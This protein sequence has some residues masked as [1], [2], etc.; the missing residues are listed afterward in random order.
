VN[1]EKLNLFY[2]WME[3]AGYTGSI[4][5]KNKGDTLCVATAYTRVFG[6]NGCLRD[7][8]GNLSDLWGTL[9][10]F[11]GNLRIVKVDVPRKARSFK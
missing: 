2:L 5:W 9:R 4:R 6:Q 3:P 8:W 7:L 11:Y 1:G 10:D